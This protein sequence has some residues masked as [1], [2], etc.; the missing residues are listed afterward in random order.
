MHELL[1]ASQLAFVA[2][3]VAHRQPLRLD[4]GRDRV[5]LRAIGQLEPDS[6]ICGISI[7]IHQRM[8][9]RVAAEIA[10]SFR[11]SRFFEAQDRDGVP[12]GAFQIAR[13]EADV[14]DIAQVD[15]REIVDGDTASMNCTTL[16]SRRSG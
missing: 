11:L 1:D 16:S 12:R 8:V 4:F 9:A 2:G 15:H 5:E 6:V 3:T 13:A 10:A 14:A 7:A